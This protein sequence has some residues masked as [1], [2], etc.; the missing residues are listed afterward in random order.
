MTNNNRRDFLKSALFSSAGIVLLGCDKNEME[1]QRMPLSLFIGTSTEGASE[2]IYR[3]SLDLDSGVLSIDGLAAT[4]ENPNF[5]ALH[6][7]LDK[8]YAVGETA[9]RDGMVKAFNSSASTLSETSSGPSGTGG[10]A[11]ISVS[12]NGRVVAVA[13]YGGGKVSILGLDSSGEI[14]PARVDVVQHQGSGPNLARQESPHAHCAIFSPDGRFLFVADLGL[15]MILA[16]K[17]D[18][19]AHKLLNADKPFTTTKPGAGPRH[20]KFH[21][22][23]DFAFVINEL[24]STL[25]SFTYDKDTGALNDIETVSTLDPDFDG[26]SYCADIHVSSDGKFVYGSNRGDNSIAVFSFENSVLKLIQ[27]ESTGG[28]WPRNFAIDP[29]GNFLVVGNRRSN[30]IAL[31]N[32]NQQTGM[33]TRQG[34]MISQAS[35]ICILFD[36]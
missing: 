7:T 31:F 11:H 18:Y 32:R 33:L 9:G 22:S 2:G 14:D 1:V 8:L 30:D 35:P 10:L 15:D 16:Y 27:T 19:E 25:S 36:V 21:P 26:E 3:A 20:F 17:V 34:S 12:P 6:P 29:T 28:N 24:N 4:T 13:D 5:M 23:G